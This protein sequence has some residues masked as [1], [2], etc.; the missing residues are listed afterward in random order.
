MRELKHLNEK[1]PNRT[2]FITGAGSGLGASF[3]KLL[4]E[5]EWTLH[6]SD[7]NLQA[8]EEQ[9]ELLKEAK[10]IHLYQLDV[11]DKLGYEKTIEAIQKNANSIDLLINNAGIGDGDFFENYK[12]DAWERMMRINLM[13]VY[14]G[15]HHVLPLLLENEKGLIVNVGSAAGFM[16]APGMSAYNTA[17]AGVYAFSETLY[18]E[19]K[20]KNIHVSVVTPTFFKTNI[21]SQAS[22][23]QQFVNFA[24]K[25]MQY[26]TTNAEEMAKV[27]LEKSAKGIFHIIH[28]KEA[29]RAYFFKKWFPRLVSKQFDKM[30]NKFLER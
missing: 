26:S 10:S 6:L 15:T 17:K 16:N 14:Y 23:S 1:Y 28:P 12:L 3:A 18:H 7:I 4:S 22:G 2:A 30:M 27:V 29:R 24:Q 11:S 9:V 25:Q 20:S 19:L 13:G 8:L 5:N 21:M